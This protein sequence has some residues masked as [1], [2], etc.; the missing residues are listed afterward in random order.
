MIN[1][2]AGPVP[3]IEGLDVPDRRQSMSGAGPSYGYLPPLSAQD[4]NKFT[5]IFFNC[6]PKNGILS[7]ELLLRIILVLGIRFNDSLE[8]VR[9]PC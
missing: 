7:G 6:G 2:V 8:P 4:R 1:G 3:I 9:R 5:K